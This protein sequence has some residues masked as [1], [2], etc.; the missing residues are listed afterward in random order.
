M[1]D[2]PPNVP[3]TAVFTSDADAR[4]LTFDGFSSADSDGT[5]TGYSWNFGDGT[6]A[7]SG[8]STTHEFASAGT[9]TVALTVTDD[10]GA[11]NTVSRDVVVT[12]I[13]KLVTYATDKFSR[14]VASGW[15]SADAG[16]AWTVSSGASF[17]VGSGVGSVNLASPG[18]GPLVYLST[19]A[20]VD[21]DVEGTVS[22]DKIPVGGTAGVYEGVIARRVAGA[23]DYRA[24]VRVAPGGAVRLSLVRTNSAGT[25]TALTSEVLVNGPY[26]AGS[27]IQFR[28]QVLGTSPTTLRAKVWKF[29]DAEPSAWTQTVTDSTA[30]LQVAGSAGFHNYI[31]GSVTNAP[32]GVKFDNVAVYKATTLPDGVPAPNEA[33][34]PTF[35]SSA[36]FLRATFDGSGSTDNDGVIT[37]Y[38]WNFGDGTP[39]GSGASV[40]HDYAANG[41]YQ[42]TLTVTDEDGAPNTLQKSISV[43]EAPNQLPTAA[44]SSNVSDLDATFNAGG[45]NDPDGTISSYVWDFGDGT[46]AGTGATPSHSYAAAGTFTVKL[47]VTDNR[48]G[49]STVSHDI[50]TIAPNQKPS[51]AFSKGGT[52]LHATF[53]ASG[54]ADPDGTIASYAWDFGDGSSD[55]GATPQHDYTAA[56]TY[57]VKLT[58]TDNRGGTD[59]ASQDYTVAPQPND[60]PTAAFTKGGTWLHATFDASGSADPDGTIASYAW[61]FGDGSNGTGA[62]PQHDYTAAGTY[63]VKLTVTDNRGGT[64][65]VSQDYTVAPKPNDPPTAAFTV[66]GTWLHATFDASGSADPDGTIA[67]YAWDFGDASN[68]TG[69]TPQHDYVDPGTYTVTLTVTDN[70]SATNATSKTITVNAAPPAV[71]LASDVFERTLATGWG[72]ADLGGAWATTGSAANLAVGSGVGILKMANAGA[73]PV[74]YLSTFSSNDTDVAVKFSLDKLPVGGANGVDQGVIVRRIAGSGDY[75]TKV[76]VLPTGQVRIGL[77]RTDS[78]GTQAVVTTDVAVPEITYTGGMV[79]NVRVQAVGTSPTALKAKLWTGATEPTAWTITG[80][81]ATAALQAAGSVGFHSYLSGGATNAPIQARF[82][83]LQVFKASTLIQ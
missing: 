51:A 23:G 53:D 9:Y 4:V 3:P 80:S 79:L 54:S 13:P 7:G 67:S 47:T 32:I 17:S 37:S 1:V 72:N 50:T 63:T 14:T 18:A 27:K 58:V 76:R 82:D 70:G 48:G 60:P 26:T 66:G 19:L 77:F 16:G 81:D 20:T 31:G 69:A 15:G 74:S 30:E 57:T 28:V 22:L 36:A 83:D 2:P 56:G 42:V 61:D 65:T 75:R 10:D 46:A 55:T 59:T 33:P 25:E 41:T 52:W 68:G 29:G 12:N 40:T 73:G 62:T 44:F 45:S 49:T 39:A 8:F 5:V 11:T 71:K 38:S 78:A 24:K 43:A 35:A 21:N 34:T 64:D 6:P